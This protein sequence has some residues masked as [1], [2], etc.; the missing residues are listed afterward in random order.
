MLRNCLAGWFLALSSGCLRALWQ[1][2][3]D[4]LAGANVTGAKVGELE[5]SGMAYLPQEPQT[6]DQR[7]HDRRT[8]L[9]CSGS[10]AGTPSD[11]MRKK[12]AP[13]IHGN[14]SVHL[15][16]QFAAAVTPDLYW[17]SSMTLSLKYT[18]AFPLHVLPP[19]YQKSMSDDG[20]PAS[21]AAC[22]YWQRYQDLACPSS[23]WG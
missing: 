18:P 19:S 13:E 16:S 8:L 17:M 23:S 14:F 12:S 1:L 7:R 22:H 11:T 9:S 10:D 21:R 2:A 3:C 5:A 15:I 20:H 6:P 4:V